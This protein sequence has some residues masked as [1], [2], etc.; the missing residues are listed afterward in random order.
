MFVILRKEWG[1]VRGSMG[2]AA[3]PIRTSLFLCHIGMG[4]RKRR[5]HCLMSFAFLKQRGRLAGDFVEAGYW[6]TNFKI[7]MIEGWKS[8][9][10]SSRSDESTDVCQSSWATF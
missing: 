1:Y 3:S 2:C 9:Y 4:A 6:D 5:G 10:R 7:A 8:E